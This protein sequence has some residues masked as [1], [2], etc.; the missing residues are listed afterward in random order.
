MVSSD[1]GKS[2]SLKR[3]HKRTGSTGSAK[4]VSHFSL[5]I[6]FR[7]RHLFEQIMKC[8]CLL[9]SSVYLHN[10]NNNHTNIVSIHPVHV[11]NAELTK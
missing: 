10:S 2:G 1:A 5:L 8:R 4:S 6:T 9:A 11:M 3:G 7:E